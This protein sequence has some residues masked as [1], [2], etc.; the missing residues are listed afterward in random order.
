MRKSKIYYWAEYD[1]DGS[2]Q[3][4]RTKTETAPAHYAHL[5]GPFARFGI[6]RAALVHALRDCKNELTS[7]IFQVKMKKAESACDT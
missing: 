4:Y 2:F 6:A 5:L 7:A 3:F 1:L